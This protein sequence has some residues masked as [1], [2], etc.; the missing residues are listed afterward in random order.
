MLG[1]HD[2]VSPILALIS[3]IGEDW[4]KE[5]AKLILESVPSSIMLSCTADQELIDGPG[6]EI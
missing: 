4:G 3:G 1:G 2:H 5:T 6:E